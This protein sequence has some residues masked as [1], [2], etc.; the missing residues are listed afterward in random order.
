MKN[1]HPIELVLVVGLVLLEVAAALAVALVA[2]V[3]TVSACSRQRATSAPLR[4]AP[5]APP[6]RAALAAPLAAIADHLRRL[7]AARLRE[8][9][10]T[11]RRC[12]KDRLIADLLAL[13]I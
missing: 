4:V 3:L 13:P 7:P 11:R 1:A 10:G 9:S 5:P 6:A 8:I 12:S 2:L